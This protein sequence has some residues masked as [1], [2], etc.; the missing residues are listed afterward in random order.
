MS[1]SRQFVHP[2]HIDCQQETR[3]SQN[4]LPPKCSYN[5]CK[6]KTSTMNCNK[7]YNTIK[8]L[9]CCLSQCNAMTKAY[10]HLIC[11][12]F[13]T[14]RNVVSCNV[15]AS[16]RWGR[17][18]SHSTSNSEYKSLYN[19]YI[20]EITSIM[21]IT[22]QRKLFKRFRARKLKSHIAISYTRIP[23]S[24]M[25]TFRMIYIQDKTIIYYNKLNK[26]I[27]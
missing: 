7:R 18:F 21:H 19:R 22:N 4:H 26:S 6:D 24:Y 5:R 25:I 27:V 13:N 3:W 20:V 12:T 23:W 16:T 14:R 15:I 1:K 17:T 8:I 11:I 9:K 10:M 2:P